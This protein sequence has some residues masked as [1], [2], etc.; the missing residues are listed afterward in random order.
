MAIL[1]GACERVFGGAFA[2]Q[3]HPEHLD[4]FRRC[5]GP[6]GPL[7]F[8]MPPSTTMNDQGSSSGPPQHVGLPPGLSGPSL[9]CPLL[10]LPLASSPRG[11][12]PRFALD[13]AGCP[14]PP[15]TSGPPRP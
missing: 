4:F 11:K 13:L 7:T 9:L 6:Y 8:S 15:A 14:R 5:A 10:L 2:L 1:K 3:A 12:R